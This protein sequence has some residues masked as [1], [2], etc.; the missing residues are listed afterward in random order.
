MNL[1]VLLLAAAGLLAAADKKDVKKDL[2][3][4]QGTWQ[5]EEAEMQGR[6]D[7]QAEKKKIVIE[8]VKLT[9]Y[10][11]GNEGTIDRI[12]LNAGADP[13]TIDFLE[14]RGASGGKTK[15]GLYRL[16]E[17]GNKLEMCWNQPGDKRPTK[18]STQPG[19]G[20]ASVLWVFKLVKK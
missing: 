9:F 14:V 17:D 4:M 15:L 8:G 20:K 6:K 13:K 1:S 3:S 2:K 11:N 10:Y 7:A 18:F 16:S 19:E 5:M 12:S